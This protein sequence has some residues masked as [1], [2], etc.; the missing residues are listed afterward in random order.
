M[1]CGWSCKNTLCYVWS[2]IIRKYIKINMHNHRFE[3]NIISLILYSDFL[4]MMKTVN[5]R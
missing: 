4:H 1:T 5:I 2:K 3:F